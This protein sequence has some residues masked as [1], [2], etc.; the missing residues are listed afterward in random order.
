MKWFPKKGLIISNPFKKRYWPIGDGQEGNWIYLSRGGNRDGE[1]NNRR[2]Q[3]LANFIQGKKKN[4]L[5]PF[6]Q[7]REALCL[8]L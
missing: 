5:L 8:S 7:E 2:R 6:I 4:T 1:R 3:Q